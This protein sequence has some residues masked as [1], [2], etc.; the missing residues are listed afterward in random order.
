MP[1]YKMVTLWYRTLGGLDAIGGVLEPAS[2]ESYNLE[3]K[4]TGG[5]KGR[6]FD[7]YIYIYSA[8]FNMKSVFMHC[9]TVC[10]IP[11]VICIQYTYNI[12]NIY[13]YMLNNIFYHTYI[14]YTQTGVF[15]KIMVPPNHPL[16]NMVFSMKK[17]HH[18]FWWVFPPLF[19][20]QHPY[21]L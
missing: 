21:P 5:I 12:Y 20:V 1:S 13:M 6:C 18:P 16:K 19:L 17:N 11:V 10:T 15:P 3:C 2:S 4:R 7:L 14:F 8:M 9:F